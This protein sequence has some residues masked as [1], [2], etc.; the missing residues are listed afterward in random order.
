[1]QGKWEA[2][3]LSRFEEFPELE[4]V[5]LGVV[6]QTEGVSCEHVGMPGSLQWSKSPVSECA[7]V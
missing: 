1:M 6:G 2:C 4:A 3:V 5:L 7:L